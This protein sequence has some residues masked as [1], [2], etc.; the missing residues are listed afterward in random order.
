MSTFQ[1][2]DGNT[3]HIVDHYPE[4]ANT[5]PEVES[6]FADSNFRPLADRVDNRG[7]Q[8]YRGIGLSNQNRLLYVAFSIRNGQIRPISCR[9][10]SRKERDR[11]DQNIQTPNPENSVG[12]TPDPDNSRD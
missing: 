7:E 10:A 6:V 9:P 1:W 11:Y 5:M 8:Q 12:D 4:R 2:D 3:A